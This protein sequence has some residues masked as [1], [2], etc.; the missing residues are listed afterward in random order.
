MKDMIKQMND[1]QIICYVRHTQRH[2]DK[3]PYVLS[4]GLAW[5]VASCHVNVYDIVDD[6]SI[7][8]RLYAEGSMNVDLLNVVSMIYILKEK[9]GYTGEKIKKEVGDIKRQ[10]G[11]LIFSMS[12]VADL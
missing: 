3:S 9:H 6:S 11:E 8:F 10:Y 12:V 5:Y 4:R 7:I 1:E 2:M